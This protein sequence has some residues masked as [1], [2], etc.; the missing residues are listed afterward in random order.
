MLFFFLLLAVLLPL[1]LLALIGPK[2]ILVKLVWIFAAALSVTTGIMLV[3]YGGFV[4]AC[5]LLFVASGTLVAVTAIWS[6]FRLRFE[7]A[8]AVSP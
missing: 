8:G 5:G 4:T 7:K 6:Y 1:I 3:G 2:L